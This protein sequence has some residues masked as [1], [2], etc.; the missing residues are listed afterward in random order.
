MKVSNGIVGRKQVTVEF[1]GSNVIVKR[2]VIGSKVTT[3]PVSRVTSVGFKKAML[4]AGYIEFIAAGFD[5]KVEFG[6]LKSRQFVALR[7]EVEA[8]L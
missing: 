6:G 7:Q 4:T 3:I 5:G 8:A 1:D 2:G